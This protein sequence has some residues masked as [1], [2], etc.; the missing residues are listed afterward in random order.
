MKKIIL[1]FLS[2]IIISCNQRNDLITDDL[3]SVPYVNAGEIKLISPKSGETICP[4]N[5]LKIEWSLSNEVKNV[6]ILLLRKTEIKKVLAIATENT[7]F[8]IWPVPVDFDNSVHYRI[9][10]I[11]NDVP[12]L[13]VLSGYFFIKTPGD[14][15]IEN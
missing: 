4:G 10:I 2:L 11:A 8:F 6:Q 15:S 9:K 5:E 12:R 3:K 1:L 7:G 13:N 14:I